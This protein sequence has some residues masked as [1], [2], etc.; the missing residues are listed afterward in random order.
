MSSEKNKLDSKSKQLIVGIFAVLIL[1]TFSA[2]MLIAAYN[3]SLHNDDE[4]TTSAVNDLQNSVPV[5]AVT[6]TDTLQNNLTTTGDSKEPVTESDGG[7]SVEEKVSVEGLE[8]FTK[9]GDNQ[10][11]DSPDNEFIKLVVNE[12][13]ADAE[14][15][16][17]IYA[18]PDLGNNFVLE[19]D[20]K[21][22]SEGNIIRSPKTLKRIY[23]INKERNITVATGKPT[24]NEGV[25]YGTSLMTY[26]LVTDVVMPEFPDYFS[27]VG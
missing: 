27:D 1:L 7:Q 20:N 19:F 4:S 10:I 18:I 25:D 14:N 9:T 12:K 21:R 16:V 13:G 26:Y 5:S 22:D 17:A 11:S 3:F 2:V 6:T 8:E 24:G 23:H 15:L